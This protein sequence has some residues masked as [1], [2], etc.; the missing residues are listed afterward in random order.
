M[1]SVKST[2]KRLSIGLLTIVGA[3]VLLTACNKSDDQNIDLPA[4]G[5]MA[6]NLVSDKPAIGIALSGNSIN[7]SPL[8]YTAF[9]GQYINIYP[10]NRSVEA[11]DF[12]SLNGFTNS[13]HAF[14][15]DKYYSLFVVGADSVYRNVIVNDNFDS[16]SASNGKAYIRFVNA[17]PDSSAPVVKITSGGSDVI[18]RPA[19]FASVS[20]FTEVNPGSL[21]INVSN[22]G[23][24]SATRAIDVADKNA[25]TILLTGRPGATNP[26]KAI[27]IKF[28]R[29]GALTDSTS[30]Q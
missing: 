20:S 22:G 1:K 29:N 28:I 26:D 3:G 9:T 14:E 23:N 8:G 10:G 18:N 6:F 17:I 24:I 16:L 7:P 25:Y 4:A 11:Y 12:M 19:G 5:L 2:L 30:K 21:N 15:A 13:T 27:Q